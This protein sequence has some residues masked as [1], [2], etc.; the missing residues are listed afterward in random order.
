[1]VAV[2]HG[3]LLPSSASRCAGLACDERVKT[4]LTTHSL[5]TKYPPSLPCQNTKSTTHKVHNGH[6]RR[7]RGVSLYVTH[8]IR[9]RRTVNQT[10]AR[11][12]Y[13]VR[14]SA[15]NSHFYCSG[16]PNENWRGELNLGIRMGTTYFYG[17]DQEII[18]KRMLEFMEQ[19]ERISRRHIGAK[20]GK[21][22]KRS[23]KPND[24]TIRG[25]E[26]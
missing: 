3:S 16:A 18:A 8:M 14:Y 26:R 17:D 22:E 1:M 7:L 24:A 6:F 13:Q 23:E 9:Y 15:P 11:K 20:I 19:L 10:L 21:P 4:T 5:W 12:A 2:R 25:A